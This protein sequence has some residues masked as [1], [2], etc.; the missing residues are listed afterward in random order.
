MAMV[1]FERGLAHA[2]GKKANSS[3]AVK[4]ICKNWFSLI[5]D[6][7]K[8]TIGQGGKGTGGTKSSGIVAAKGPEGDDNPKILKVSKDQFFSL[9]TNRQQCVR[10]LL[11]ALAT[12]KVWKPSLFSLLYKANFN[13]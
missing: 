13:F 5:S 8:A 4:E 7:S 9:C 10:R 6:A 1:S 3:K 2:M 12:L 11:E